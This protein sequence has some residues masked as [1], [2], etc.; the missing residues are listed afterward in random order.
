VERNRLGADEALRFDLTGVLRLAQLL[1]WSFCLRRSP[2]R[3]FE[4]LNGTS[5]WDS[6]QCGH[7]RG[8][9]RHVLR[10]P[11]GA[12]GAQVSTAIWFRSGEL[13]LP[14]LWY[15]RRVT[16]C[17]GRLRKTAPP[18]SRDACAAMPRRVLFTLSDLAARGT[19]E[20]S[21]FS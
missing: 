3:R 10:R 9:P 15:C 18:R 11:A 5:H 1:A 19:L 8:V 2:Q 21:G 13:P 7:S 17:L 14:P 4:R 20:P 16:L 12:L 6:L